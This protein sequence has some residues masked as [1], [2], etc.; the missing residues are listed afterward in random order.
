MD[1][2][3]LMKL[4]ELMGSRYTER[5]G[6]FSFQIEKV[7]NI[8]DSFGSIAV[9]SALQQCIVRLLI[10]IAVISALQQCIAR[11]LGKLIYIY[12]NIYIYHTILFAPYIS[13]FLTTF[14][15]I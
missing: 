12:Y 15:C 6:K 7:Y 3:K 10:A 2:V 11:R 13:Y 1:V 5:P 8:G 14:P 9:I 4:F